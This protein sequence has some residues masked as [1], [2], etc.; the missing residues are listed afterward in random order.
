MTTNATSFQSP[1][2]RFSFFYEL[3]PE[4]SESP[5]QGFNLLNGDFL[6]STQQKYVFV[7]MLPARFNLLNGDF[8]FSTRISRGICFPLLCFNLLNGDFLFSTTDTG[9]IYCAFHEFQSPERRF[10]FFYTWKSSP[11][12]QVGYRFN[13]LNGDFLFSTRYG[14]PKSPWSYTVSIS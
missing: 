4:P 3:R 6:F 12:L 14:R 10:S 8:L 2:R 13:L 1:E 11:F 5:G 9:E 7:N